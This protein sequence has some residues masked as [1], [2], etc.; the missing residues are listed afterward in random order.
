M[1]TGIFGGTFDPIH[2]GHLRVAEEVREVHGLDSVYFVP[3]YIPPHKRGQNITEPHVRKEMVAA[4]VRGN[5]G[6]RLSQFEINKGGVSYTID[7]VTTFERKHGE[8]YFLIGMDAF[9]EIDT[10]HRYR[11]IFSHTNFVVMVRPLQT[12]KRAA[13]IFPRDLR[14]EFRQLEETT[15]EH[16]SK[17]KVYFQSVTQ[18][19][20]SSTKIREFAKRG[21]SIRYLVPPGVERIIL[22]KGLYR[23]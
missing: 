14:K 21:E 18:L 7:T 10:W 17:K 5:P 1:R 20:I 9:S 8:L 23:L 4:A 19:D 6:F 11:E 2:M 16:V 12:R 15:F 3:G 22:R 13:K